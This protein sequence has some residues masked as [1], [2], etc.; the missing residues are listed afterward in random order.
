[1]AFALNMLH[2]PQPEQQGLV[3]SNVMGIFKKLWA[4]SVGPRMEDIMRNGLHALI[5]QPRPVSI[6]AL[7]K[8]LT[9]PE[10]RITSLA[11]VRNPA[12]LDFF[13]NTYERWSPAFRDEAISPV[14]NKC[15]AFMTDP[16]LRAVI[17][18]ARSSFDFRWAMDN[19][20]IVL[21]DLSKG[22]IGAE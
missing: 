19:G 6:L 8:L 12:V 4:G 3:V 7:P 10:Y 21:C 17:G 13:H 11:N 2:C 1:R 22:T 20:K 5:E 9:D 15:R 16:L 14:L 18:Q